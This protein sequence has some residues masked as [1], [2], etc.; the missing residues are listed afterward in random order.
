MISI[1]VCDKSTPLSLGP[2]TAKG[3]HAA[4]FRIYRGLKWANPD[5]KTEDFG[6]YFGGCIG[7]G[8]FLIFRGSHRQGRTDDTGRKF[9]PVLEGG[10]AARK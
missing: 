4:L 2:L 5:D 7:N 10:L 1:V 6:L 9:L 8:N 3:L